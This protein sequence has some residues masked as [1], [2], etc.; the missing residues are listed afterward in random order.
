M[1]PFAAPDYA[2]T[3]FCVITKSVVRVK[4]YGAG[5]P[6]REAL[7]DYLVIMFAAFRGAVCNYNLNMIVGSGILLF[8]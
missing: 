1:P 3:N 2:S 8:M 6:V 4:P 5:E 7:L